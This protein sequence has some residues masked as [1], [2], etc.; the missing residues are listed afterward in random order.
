MILNPD[1]RCHNA[2]QVVVQ[3]VKDGEADYGFNARTEEYGNLLAM[4]VVDPTKVTRTAL[5]NAASV[6]GLLLTTQSV[7]VDKPED[8][9]A[10]PAGGDMG[11]MGGG[12]GF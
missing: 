3:K 10:M 5:E 9:P 6:A 11:G 1:E 7:I 2:S 12:M 4:G 8:A